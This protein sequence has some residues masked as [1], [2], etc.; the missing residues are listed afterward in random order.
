MIAILAA[1]LFP[2]F[3]RAREKARQTSCLSNMK[4]MGLA[5]MMYAQDYDETL[6]GHILAAYTPST[7]TAFAHYESIHPYVKNEQVFMCP[8]HDYDASKWQSE[9]SAN[10]SGEGLYKRSARTSYAV[11]T[12]L[13]T[14]VP[15]APFTP[16]NPAAKLAFFERPAETVLIFESNCLW[17]VKPDQVG[18]DNDTYEPLSQDVS[19]ANGPYKGG[20]DYRHNGQANLAYAD[21]HAK[22]TSQVTS[23][24]EFT[25]NDW[26][27]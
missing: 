8:S 23:L 2:V 24:S 5:M 25:Y 4:Q 7:R 19:G 13:S 14:R 20:L 15:Y 6:P 9:R 1:I 21:G 12:R 17:V 26:P 10:P 27:N 11:V 16:H 3:A 22:S 18:F